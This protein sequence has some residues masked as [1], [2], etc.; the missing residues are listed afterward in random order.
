MY[1]YVNYQG[2]SL[3]TNTLVVTQTQQKKLT[4]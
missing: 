1:N 4:T 3:K 2:C